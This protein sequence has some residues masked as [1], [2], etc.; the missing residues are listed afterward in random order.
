[1]DTFLEEFN[2]YVQHRDLPRLVIMALTAD[3]TTGTG[4][5]YPTPTAAVADN[6]LAVGRLVAAISQSPYWKDS[7]IF[8][9]ED[10]SQDGVDHVD[11]HR[12]AGFV[13]SPYA[14]QD[15][16]VDSTFYTQINIDRTIEQILGLPPMNQF[17]QGAAPMFTAFT[18]KPNFTPFQ[19]VAATYPVNQLNPGSLAATKLE[20]EWSRTS[21]RMVAGNE[22]DP[23]KEDETMMNHLVWYSATGFKRPYP[24]EK[25]VLRPSALLRMEHGKGAKPDRDG[26]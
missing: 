23:D 2:Q 17:D 12:Q 5:G 25:A 4:A 14:R 19:A 3:H 7:A 16:L 9:E 1:M 24:G 11:G 10:D 20:R 18:D 13:I 8:V 26:D 22:H 6:D 15:G 21:E